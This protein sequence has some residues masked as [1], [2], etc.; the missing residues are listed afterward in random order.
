MGTLGYKLS[1][2]ACWSSFM[3]FVCTQGQWKAATSVQSSG[4]TDRQIDLLDCTVKEEV[5]EDCPRD[6]QEMYLLVVHYVWASALGRELTSPAPILSLRLSLQDPKFQLQT[7]INSW[8]CFRS[9][10]FIVLR[11]VTPASKAFCSFSSSVLQV[12]WQF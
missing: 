2:C 10:G 8:C 12:V 5:R 6:L 7:E 1:C 4:Q 11:P 9:P 3:L